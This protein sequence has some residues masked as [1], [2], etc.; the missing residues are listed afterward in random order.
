MHVNDIANYQWSCS[1]QV[2]EPLLFV[3]Y[4]N[5]LPDSIIFYVCIKLFADAVKLLTNSTLPPDV[6]NVALQEHL[7]MLA[8][9]RVQC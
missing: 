1:G 4:I 2:F 3:L 5:N 8:M 6:K 7:D 9:N